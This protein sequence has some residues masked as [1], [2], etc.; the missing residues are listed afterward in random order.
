LRLFPRWLALSSCHQSSSPGVIGHC[1]EDWLRTEDSW[2]GAEIINT[3]PLSPDSQKTPKTHCRWNHAPKNTRIRR[4]VSECVAS[5]SVTRAR[6]FATVRGDRPG[7]RAYMR[8]YQ[9]ERLAAWRSDWLADKSCAVRGSRERLE[10]DHSATKI[11]SSKGRPVRAACGRGRL[12]VAR[13]SWRSVSA[14]S[15]SHAF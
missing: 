3:C 10:I 11:R 6:R 5:A 4:D 12:I 7:R 14:L 1:P 8:K 9:R 2:S 13:P 15:M